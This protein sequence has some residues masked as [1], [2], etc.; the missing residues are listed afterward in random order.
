MDLVGEWREAKMQ[1]LRNH[2]NL[3]AEKESQGNNNAAFSF[4]ILKVEFMVA[5]WECLATL[6][7][8]LSFKGNEF[9]ILS[10][11]KWWEVIGARTVL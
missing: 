6:K 9:Y 4:S 7:F 2:A 3:W 11:G 8:S 10:D 1:L 5:M